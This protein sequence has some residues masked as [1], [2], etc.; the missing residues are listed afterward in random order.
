M[1]S[2][3]KKNCGYNYCYF[4]YFVKIYTLESTVFE[5]QFEL[6]RVVVLQIDSE[7]KHS[8]PGGRL[9]IVSMTNAQFPC[10][11]LI[12][13]DGI[14]MD[15]TSMARHIHVHAH[16]ETYARASSARASL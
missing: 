3:R 5:I 10:L 16:R 13:F 11:E 2:V 9:S 12:H 6:N 14:C 4:I 15:R 8:N 7:S 1:F